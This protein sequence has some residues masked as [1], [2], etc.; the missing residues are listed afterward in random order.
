[1]PTLVVSSRWRFL[2]AALVGAGMY[3]ALL[4]VSYGFLQDSYIPPSW[5]QD[6]LRVPPVNAI[7]W[8]LLI[9]GAGALFTAIPVAFCLARFAKTHIFALSIAVG[10]PPSLYIIGSGLAEY[11]L[12]R[13]AAAWIIEVFHFASISLAIPLVVAFF[14][15]RPN[16]AML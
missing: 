12:P 9:N 2:L 15:R 11:G 7:S 14:P 6:H 3:L 1:V 16:R 4:R 8:F 5:W 13:Y 10:V